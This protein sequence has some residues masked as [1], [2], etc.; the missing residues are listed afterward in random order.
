MSRIS[1]EKIRR[2]LLDRMVL[3]PSRH[4]LEHPSQRRV[5]LHVQGQPLECFVR[6]NFDDGRPPDLL[7]L[8]F[9]GTAGRA[10]RSSEFPISMLGDARVAIWTWNPPGYGR[11]GGRA[12]LPRIAQA[13][14][15][16][17]TQVQQSYGDP[18]MS[19][20]L[21]G[22]S[23]GCVTALHVAATAQLDPTRSGMIMRNPPPLISVVTRVTKQYPLSGLMRGV[24]DSLC[25]SMNAMLTAK[26]VELPAVFLQ[27]ELDT[28]VPPSDQ[29]RLIEAYAGPR[30]VVNL[31]GLGHGCIATELHEPLI[32]ASI[33][34]L[35]GQTGCKIDEP[36]SA[37]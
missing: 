22:N 19:V 28:L 11:S 35:W 14:L 13:A 29:D 20:W 31:Q 27:S 18:P 3:R 16:F 15:E 4:P 32:Q 24:I 23:L 7:V 5:M 1:R 21:C 17:Q 25:D 12:S 10:E 2:Y 30:Q 6:K 8:K 9:P 36:Y 37:S 33:Q 26:Q 34:W